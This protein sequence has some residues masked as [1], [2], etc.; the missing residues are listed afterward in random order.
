M[1]GKDDWLPPYTAMNLSQ[2]HSVDLYMM[3]SVLSSH[4][5]KTIP[6]NVLNISQPILGENLSSIPSFLE[7]GQPLGSPFQKHHD[8]SGE[9]HQ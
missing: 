2:N 4:E 3:E 7:S 8:Q 1:N 6:E 5:T 9:V